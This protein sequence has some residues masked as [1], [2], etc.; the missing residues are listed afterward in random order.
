MLTLLAGCDRIAF[1]VQWKQAAADL[2]RTFPS[3][4]LP[5][6]V[7][8]KDGVAYIPIDDTAF[9]VPEKTWLRGYARNSTDG[10]VANIAL[11]ASVPDVQPWSPER[12]DAMYWKAGPGLSLRIDIKGGRVS[13]PDFDVPRSQRPHGE[14]IEEPSDQAEQGLRRFRRSWGEYPEEDAAKDKA[15]FGADFVE[16]M[17]SHNGKPM[18][19]T[20]YY[21]Y[22]QNDRV[23]YS[24]Y[25][26]DG[27]GLFHICH[28]LMTWTPT[29]AIDIEFA[30]RDIKHIVA[31]AD[32]VSERLRE[33]EAAGLAH[34]AAIAAPTPPVSASSTR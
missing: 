9:L 33:F 15:R 23:K 13:A 24:I 16:R 14:F 21:E 32:K 6:P 5:D 34:R 20:V 12:N 17:R 4:P 19:D 29:V 25:C 11:H 3:K 1:W 2:T 8:S 22:I 27:D 30:R 26:S 7:Q 28:L 18:M 31:M 10:L